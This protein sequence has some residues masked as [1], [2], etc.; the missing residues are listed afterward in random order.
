MVLT[1]YIC[2]N[3]YEKQINR[4]FFLAFCLSDSEWRNK[5]V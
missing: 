3:N 5:L 1:T 2:K 4:L